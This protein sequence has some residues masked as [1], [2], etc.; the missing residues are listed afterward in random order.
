MNGII[1]TLIAIALATSVT[2]PPA[3]KRQADCSKVKAQI[4]KV[5]SQMRAGYTRAQ[6]ERLQARLLKLRKKRSRTCR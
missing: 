3:D 2:H 4:R 6:G 5:E 1:A